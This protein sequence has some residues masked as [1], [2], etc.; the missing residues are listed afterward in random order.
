MLS[1]F[2]CEQGDGDISGRQLLNTLVQSFV[3]TCEQSSSS[4]N[5]Y[6]IVE[7]FTNV[8]VAFFDAVYNHLVDT[9]PLQT[10]LV[11]AEK[12]LWS[13]E[14]LGPELNNLAIWQMVV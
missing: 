6:R 4:S 5:H 9:W 10:N 7:G 1:I 3:E 14:F 11:W 12:N 2:W 8:N 13:L